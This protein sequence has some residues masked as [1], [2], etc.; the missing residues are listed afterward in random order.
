MQK[1]KKLKRI[2]VQNPCRSGLYFVVFCLGVWAV[3]KEV[4]SL[5]WYYLTFLGIVS[6][7][8]AVC[9]LYLW[10]LYTFPDPRANWRM[11]SMSQLFEE[12]QFSFW[13]HV[14]KFLKEAF[15]RPRHD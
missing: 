11:I 6:L 14:W 5:P 8:A 7:A 13:R 4:P 2:V 3:G 15:S 10:Y 9:S 1:L 12:M